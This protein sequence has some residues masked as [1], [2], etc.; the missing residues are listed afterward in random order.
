[1]FNQPFLQG[2]AFFVFVSVEYAVFSAGIKYF[3]IFT[4]YCVY[5]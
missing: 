5:K 3:N 4:G 1:M 2:T